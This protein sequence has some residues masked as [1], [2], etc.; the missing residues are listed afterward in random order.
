MLPKYVYCCFLDFPFFNNFYFKYI[1]YFPNKTF[2]SCEKFEDLVEKFKTYEPKLTKGNCETLTTYEQQQENNK[3]K[4]MKACVCTE[5]MCNGPAKVNSGIS[6]FPLNS[7]I[8]GRNTLVA[9][10]PMVLGLIILA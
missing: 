1:V 5:D 7:G 4:Q 2:R 8:S 3:G 10:V 9:M 6:G